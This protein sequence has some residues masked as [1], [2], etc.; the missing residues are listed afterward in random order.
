MSRRAAVALSWDGRVL[1]EA[2]ENFRE[3][4]VR[5]LVEEVVIT[6][7]PRIV[8]GG[9]PPITGLGEDFL[10]RGISLELLRLERKGDHCR[11][12]YRVRPMGDM[13]ENGRYGRYASP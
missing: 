2:P 9:F 3:L 8:G 12:R 5:G 6:F 13:G 10:P 1:G 7:Q 11:A 4:A